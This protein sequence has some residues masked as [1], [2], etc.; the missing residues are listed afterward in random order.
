MSAARPANDQSNAEKTYQDVSRLTSD[1]ESD[2][3]DDPVV[4]HARNSTEVADHDRGLLEEEEERE[5]LLTTGKVQQLSKGFF[6]RRRKEVG[7]AKLEDEKSRKKARRKKRRDKKSSRHD[8]EGELM[9]EMEEG[10]PRSET[11]S[12]ASQ[13]SAELDKLNLVHA[14]S[15]KVSTRAFIDVG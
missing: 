3:E 6:G 14:S 5:E 12:Q 15:S 13:S 8:E 7:P 9:Y 1:G 4:R 10:G 2:F 11:S